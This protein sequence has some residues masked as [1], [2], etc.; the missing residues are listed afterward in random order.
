M[1]VHMCLCVRMCTCVCVCVCTWVL[2]C[3]HVCFFCVHMCLRGA[4]VYWS[5][6]WLLYENDLRSLWGSVLILQVRKL[7]SRE[8][9]ECLGL[10]ENVNDERCASH[11]EPSGF[12]RAPCPG[13]GCNHTDPGNYVRGCTALAEHV[14]GAGRGPGSLLAAWL[15]VWATSLPS[16]NRSLKSFPITEFPVSLRSRC[17]FPCGKMK[18]RLPQRGA[19]L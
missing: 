19:C 18:L 7:T 14:R 4:C 11:R 9:P 8:L 12:W 3:T 1:C 6:A 16:S 10:N 17:F 15:S 13:W 2:V 5:A